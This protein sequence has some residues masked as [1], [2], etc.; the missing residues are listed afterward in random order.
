MLPIIQWQE[1]RKT[2]LLA[3]SPMEHLDVD[4]PPID[5]ALSVKMVQ[6][7]NENRKI[8]NLRFHLG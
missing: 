5:P 4:A 8:D 7:S 2:N 3:N 6:I 1:Y